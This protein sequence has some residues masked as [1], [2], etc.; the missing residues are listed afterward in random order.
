VRFRSRFAESDRGGEH[1]AILGSLVETFK[2]CGVD[3]HAYLAD[4]LSRIVTSHLNTRI[5]VLLP[6]ARATTPDVKALLH[7]LAR[8]H[9]TAIFVCR[10]QLLAVL[11]ASARRDLSRGLFLCPKKLALRAVYLAS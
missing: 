1:W 10:S 7:K 4:V 8:M 9:P 5:D 2:L 3:P 11:P 6:W